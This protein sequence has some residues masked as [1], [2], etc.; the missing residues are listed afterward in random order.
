MRP[1]APTREDV[2]R[3][4]RDAGLRLPREELDAY[5]RLVAASLEGLANLEALAP[6]PAPHAREPGR[7]P[8]PEENP[9]GAWAWLARVPGA[10]EGPLARRR[11]ALK[12][13]VMLAGV[14]MSAGS[15]V[16]AG[17][18]PEQDATV[19]TRLL[20]AG[21]DVV[22][23]TACEDLCFSGG[24]HTSATGPVR[25]PHDPARM[26]GGSSSGSAVVVATGEADLALGGDQG[27]SIVIPAAWC[28]V[29]GLKP[30][31]G[32]VPC[33]GVL[34]TEPTLDHVGPLA[35]TVREAAAALEVLAGPDGLDPR[36]PRDLA[37]ARYADACDAPAEGLRV[38][39]LREGFAWEGL[40]E[41]DVDALA[42]REVERRLGAAGADVRE[43]SAPMHRLAPDVQHGVWTEG[44][45]AR[46]LDGRGLMPMGAGPHSPAL[47][48]AY[49]RGW[50]ER[51]DALAPTVKL[52][53]LLARHVRAH[54][55]GRYHAL[56]Q[57]A[58]AR[59]RAAY[60]EALRGVDVLALPTVPWK[61]RPLPGPDATVEERV[62]LAHQGP[63]ACGFDLT[64]HPSMSVPA[65]FSQGLP[66]GVLLVAR[67]WD[68]RTLLRAGAAFERGA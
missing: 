30:T 38:G 34:A 44:V 50:R 7:A 11:V 4:A 66:V 19:V 45:L 10:A 57:G 52:A 41:P 67:A 46:F 40:S 18:V 25:N 43:V 63:N 33:T 12:D 55:P 13:V 5:A 39:L 20:A 24:S 64:G 27:G 62:R 8:A 54:A 28:G 35:R 37:P 49:A 51:A 14:P 68:E 23:K 16:L 32:L 2:E 58:R 59:L 29:V 42:R 61:A 3:Y 9:L 17:F 56:A 21:A 48:D 1:P 22:G 47:A 60:D 31:F 36:Q 26:A 53:A 6:P 65:G 15:A